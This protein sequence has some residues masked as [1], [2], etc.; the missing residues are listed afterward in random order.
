MGLWKEFEA[1]CMYVWQHDLKV[2]TI[3]IKQV[4]IFNNTGTGSFFF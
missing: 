4:T 1:H 3:N 2:D